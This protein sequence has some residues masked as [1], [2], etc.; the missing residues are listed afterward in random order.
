M[1][2]AGDLSGYIDERLAAL[3]C[4]RR[5]VL[6]VPQ[7]N[8][9]SALLAGTDIIATVPDYAAAVLT[10]GGGLRED[11]VPFDAPSFELSMAWRGPR[12]T[13]L[14]SAGCVHVSR[15]LSATPIPY[16]SCLH[17][18]GCRPIIRR[19]LS[20]RRNHHSER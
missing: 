15:C 14:P 8:G 18:R 7:F 6:A 20:L 10:A 12:I 2:F 17:W 3:G 11:D 16:G 5:V 13:T 1:S 4:R 19:F 9:L